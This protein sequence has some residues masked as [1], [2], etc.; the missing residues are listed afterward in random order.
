MKL[1]DVFGDVLRGTLVYALTAFGAS[2]GAHA[3]PLLDPVARAS[4]DVTPTSDDREQTE[5]FDAQCT[6][7]FEKDG[8]VHHFAQHVFSRP[9]TPRQLSGVRVLAYVPNPSVPGYPFELVTKGI[10]VRDGAV[11]VECDG[12]EHVTFITPRTYKLDVDTSSPW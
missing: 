7:T 11:A 8:V 9:R 6:E 12:F 2:V 4:A 1:R 3:S 10:F 5:A